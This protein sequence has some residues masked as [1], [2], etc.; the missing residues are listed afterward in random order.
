MMQ[1]CKS[2]RAFRVGLGPCSG[3]YVERITIDNKLS[4][5]QHNLFLENRV[6]RLVG[7]II[8]KVRY[9]LPFNTLLTLYYAVII[10]VLS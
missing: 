7:G 1:S 2:G 10:V 5:G 3:Q 4:F 6:A 8:V 9:H